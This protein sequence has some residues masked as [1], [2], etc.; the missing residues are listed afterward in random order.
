[1]KHIARKNDMAVVTD[2]GESDANVHLE[3]SNPFVHIV[4]AYADRMAVY[5]MMLKHNIKIFRKIV[6][7][8]NT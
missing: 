1:M 8:L 2:S 4:D 7:S 3:P 6:P 5:D